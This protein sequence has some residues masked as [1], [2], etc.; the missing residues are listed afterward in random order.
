MLDSEINPSY[1]LKI[2]NYEEWRVNFVI[3]TALQFR[4]R[5]EKE[6]ILS[7]TVISF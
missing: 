3:Y 5:W 6:L 4:E 7:W 2:M 1:F